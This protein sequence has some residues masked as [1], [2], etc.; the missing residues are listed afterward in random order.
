M[1]TLRAVAKHI[2]G[3]LELGHGFKEYYRIQNTTY[4][5]DSMVCE[6][7]DTTTGQ[8][9][10]ISITPRRDQQDELRKLPEKL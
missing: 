7:V 4:T 6:I 5:A 9:Y 3:I 2:N 8:V 10:D 1:Q